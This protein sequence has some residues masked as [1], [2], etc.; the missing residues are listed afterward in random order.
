VKKKKKKNRSIFKYITERWS[1]FLFSGIVLYFLFGIVLRG[2]LKNYLLNNNSEITKAVIVNEENYWGN[3]PVSQ[4]FSY[5]YEF[6]VEGKKYREDSR[7]EKLR[8]GDSIIIEYVNSY[9][10]FSRVKNEK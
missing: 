9:P 4:K 8:I 6:S 5:S 10:K 3:S 2:N 1:L 7:N